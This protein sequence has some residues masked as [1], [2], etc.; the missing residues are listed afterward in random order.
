MKKN[1]L[2]KNQISIRLTDERWSHIIEEHCELAGM[3]TDIL[4]TIANP[5][6]IVLGKFNELLAC[7]KYKDNKYI[8]AVYKE[9]KKDGFIITSFLTSRLKSLKKRKQI[10]PL[11]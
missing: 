4:E 8:V 7:K 10:W 2:S 5:D 3:Q 9:E 11:H 1:V 6:F